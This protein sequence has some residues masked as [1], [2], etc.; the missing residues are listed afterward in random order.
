MLKELTGSLVLL[1]EKNKEKCGFGGTTV[2][3]QLIWEEKQY[4]FLNVSF[5]ALVG[6][7]E[8]KAEV[9]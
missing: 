7:Y 8:L 5:K 6:N 9:C 3:E 1:S 2:I 4:F